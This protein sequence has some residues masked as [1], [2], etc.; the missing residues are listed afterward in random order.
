MA[1][2]GRSLKLIVV[3]AERPHEAGVL[4]SAGALFRAEPPQHEVKARNVDAV[5]DVSIYIFLYFTFF[6][7]HSSTFPIHML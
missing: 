5:D 3:D 2:S 1:E 6:S 7:F 4:R